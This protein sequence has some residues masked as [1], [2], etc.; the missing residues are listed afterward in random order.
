MTKKV[1]K[2]ISSLEQL[3]SG[4]VSQS[5]IAAS[6]IDVEPEL[7]EELQQI[8]VAMHYTIQTLRQRLGLPNAPR[9]NVTQIELPSDLRITTPG[10]N[11]P[12]KTA[13]DRIEK[14]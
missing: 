10:D 11:Q 12:I 8:A 7:M 4:V 14:A 3:V 6:L 9:M 2:E 13:G 1:E 5:R